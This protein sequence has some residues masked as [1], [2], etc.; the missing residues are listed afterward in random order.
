MHLP[1]LTTSITSI[2]FLQKYNTTTIISVQ[3]L[4]LQRFVILTD[5]GARIKLNQFACY[6]IFP[7][8]TEITINVIN[9]FAQFYHWQ[10]CPVGSV[11]QRGGEGWCCI[12]IL[13]RLRSLCITI[14]QLIDDSSYHVSYPP[15]YSRLVAPAPDT[16]PAQ[17]NCGAGA[18]TPFK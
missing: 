17:Y 11:C 14:W 18:N 3:I 8:Q 15:T 12:S 9:R 10:V 16:Q 7:V 2:Q 5:A 4:K 1:S 13:I 6:W